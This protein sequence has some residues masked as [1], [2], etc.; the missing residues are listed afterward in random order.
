[1]KKKNCSKFEAL[2]ESLQFELPIRKLPFYLILHRNV[3]HTST[4]IEK[5]LSNPHNVFF[6]CAVIP[7][8][9]ISG[10][11]FVILEYV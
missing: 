3:N 7:F 5:T 1:M 6:S 8:L 11:Y 9:S 10:W 4:N 2:K